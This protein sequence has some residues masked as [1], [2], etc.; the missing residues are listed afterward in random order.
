MSFPDQEIE[1]TGEYLAIDRPE[2]LMFTWLCSDTGDLESV[3]TILFAAEGENET[4]MTIM[5]T[6]QPAQL[7]ANTRPGGAP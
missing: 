6:Q 5:H 3:V 2:R 4:L 1:V 7:V